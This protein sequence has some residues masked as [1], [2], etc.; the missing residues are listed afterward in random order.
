MAE[1]AAGKRS[2]KMDFAM[3]AHSNATPPLVFPNTTEGPKEIQRGPVLALAE[4]NIY[5]TQ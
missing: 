2:T 4:P 1:A 3:A 5:P